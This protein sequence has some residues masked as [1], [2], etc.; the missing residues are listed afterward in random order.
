MEVFVKH[1]GERL[2]VLN[3]NSN[4]MGYITKTDVVM[5]FRDLVATTST[6]S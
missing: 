3:T 4:L 6:V 2:P 1:P 5:L